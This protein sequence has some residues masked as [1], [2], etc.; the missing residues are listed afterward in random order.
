MDGTVYLLQVRPKGVPDT[1]PFGGA[2]LEW[3]VGWIVHVLRYRGQWVVEVSFQRKDAARSSR[4]PPYAIEQVGSVTTRVAAL[5][6]LA[7]AEAALGAGRWSP[8][9]PWP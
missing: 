4:M 9:A 2:A 5:S 3:L 6:R 1:V 8:P 7:E